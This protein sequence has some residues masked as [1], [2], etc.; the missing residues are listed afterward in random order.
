MGHPW[1][2]GLHW[3]TKKCYL[4]MCTGNKTENCV[5]EYHL[6]NLTW[7]IYSTLQRRH[8]AA[9]LTH[10]ARTMLKLFIRAERCGDWEL[11]LYSNAEFICSNGS[12]ELCKMWASAFATNAKSKNISSVGI[13]KFHGKRLSYCET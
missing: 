9:E 1:V 10:Y 11:H 12:F 13:Q 3:W 5:Q 7:E 2:L 4:K 6:L 8:S